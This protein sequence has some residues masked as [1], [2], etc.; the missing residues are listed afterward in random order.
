M[1][2]WAINS[3]EYVRRVVG[4]MERLSHDSP[5]V[6]ERT[7]EG[8]KLYSELK[9]F[10]KLYVYVRLAEY[11]PHWPR[12]MA[13]SARGLTQEATASMSPWSLGQAVPRRVEALA[14]QVPRGG[15]DHSIC[16]RV[17][18][19]VPPKSAGV[20][21]QGDPSGRGS[22]VTAPRLEASTTK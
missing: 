3:I 14:G 8:I 20:D 11:A 15:V 21:P 22:L 17:P 13:C 18:E 10:Q 12:D 4:R 2:V 16:A 19:P 7:A 5:V 9:H 1:D 6:Q